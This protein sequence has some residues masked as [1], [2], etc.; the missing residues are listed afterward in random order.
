MINLIIQLFILYFLQ[1]M[2][3]SLYNKIDYNLIQYKYNTI[4]YI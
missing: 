2:I 1:K 3:N 4:D